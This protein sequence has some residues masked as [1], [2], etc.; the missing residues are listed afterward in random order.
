MCITL[1][2]LTPSPG[3]GAL[4]AISVLCVCITPGGAPGRQ[5]TGQHATSCRYAGGV[6][7]AIEALYS[8][9]VC[10]PGG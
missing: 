7:S 1:S 5:I 2:A 8:A 3:S 9:M 10:S 6:A 4:A